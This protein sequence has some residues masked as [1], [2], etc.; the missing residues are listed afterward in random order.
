MTKERPHI[1]VERLAAINAVFGAIRAAR[2]PGVTIGDVVNDA[3]EKTY[4]ACD[5]G[6]LGLEI[7]AFE[8]GQED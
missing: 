7:M 2:N 6:S 3:L 8:R 4:A 5:T 1:S